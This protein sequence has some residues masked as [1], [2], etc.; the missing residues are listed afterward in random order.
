MRGVGLGRRDLLGSL[1]ATKDIRRLNAYQLRR[2]KRPILD[3]LLGPGA[4]RTGI[5]E[6]RNEYR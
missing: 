4:V 5:N 2:M 3:D 6:G 1:Q